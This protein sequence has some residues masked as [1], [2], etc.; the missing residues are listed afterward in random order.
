MCG[1]AGVINKKAY[2]TEQLL[3]NMIAQVRHRG[4]DGFGFYND[5]KVGLA[6]ARLSIIDLT[7][8]G[9]QP[10]HNEDKTI[11]T[12]FNGEIFNYLELRDYLVAKGHKFYTNTDTEVI[13]HMYE[14]KGIDF[15]KYLNGQFAIALYDKN[16]AKTYLI[17]DRMGIRPLYYKCCDSS[18]CFAS[19]VKSIYS[20]PHVSRELDLTS[21]S[22]TF[23]Y[24]A[25]L[26][27]GSAF[28]GIKQVP[29]GHYVG[30]SLHTGKID[31]KKYWD[32]EY[33]IDMSMS[34]AECRELFLESFN[35]AVKL[36]LRSDVPVGAYL[37][38]GLDSTS[39]VRAI[40]DNSNNKLRTFSIAFED[41]QFDETSY[42]EEA[43]K[44]FGVD[45]TTFRCS[46]A[47]IVNNFEQAVYHAE[48]PILRTA[49]IPMMLLSRKVQDAGYK[50]VLTGEGADEALVGYDI[51]RET[52]LR[53]TMATHPESEKIPEMLQ[54][55]YPWRKDITKN[56]KMSKQFFGSP[57]EG[58]IDES[59]FSHVTRWKTTSSAK[60]FFAE[61]LL[62]WDCDYDC[63]NESTMFRT[64]DKTFGD[65]YGITQAQYI[66][67]HTLL[68]G[69][70]LS[71]QGDRMG[72]ANS[73]EGRYPFLDHNLVQLCDNMPI[74]MKLKFMDEKYILKL[75]M[76]GKIPDSIFQRKKQPYMAPDGKS[77]FETD[78][79]VIRLLD[80]ENV[81]N[82]GY[83]NYDAVARLKKK[84]ELGKANSFPDNM[85]MIGILSTLSLHSQFIDNFQPQPSIEPEAIYIDEKGE[86]HE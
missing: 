79:E 64:P 55:L 31:I 77:F 44:M 85:A 12:V 60:K 25:P 2:H 9:F 63:Y 27:P 33:N 47:D 61:R 81:D 45:H 67:Y 10:I 17:R 32:H 83:F 6:H 74:P 68:S 52:V 19:E 36:R 57:R 8:D 48:S 66:E 50:V 1:I 13:V 29:E 34:E 41:K 21:L 62:D 82:T 49:P 37:S 70:L 4:P 75:A 15:V 40:M 39:I 76:K 73:I 28:A 54:Q 84:F 3:Q 5:V 18:V 65:G 7:P 30:V 80:K 71:S 23:T 14:E 38:G 58:Y 43:A 20:S 56:L 24:W 51:F 22:D 16:K 11:W 86:S 42:Q 53:R 59:F 72:M 46:Y 69:Y 78:N 35:E 26:S